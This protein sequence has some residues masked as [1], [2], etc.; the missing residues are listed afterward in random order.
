MTI[1]AVADDIVALVRKRGRPISYFD[2]GYYQCEWKVDFFVWRS[3]LVQLVAS[4]RLSLT[5]NNDYTLPA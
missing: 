2:L 1:D 5:A 3:L 4:G